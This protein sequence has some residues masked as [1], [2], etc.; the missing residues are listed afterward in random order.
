MNNRNTIENELKGLNSGLS[1]ELHGNPY[2]VPQGYF[3]G[4]AAALLNRVKEGDMSAG[5]ELATLSPL[6]AGLSRQMPYSVPEN[7]FDNNNTISAIAQEEDSLVLSFISRDMP[8]AVPAGYFANLPE[9]IMEKVV[10][11][12]AKVVPLFARKWVRMT[13]A[14]VV[15]GALALSGILY[16]NHGGNAETVTKD[17]VAVELKNASTEELNAFL[18]TT[19]VTSVPSKTAAS[20]P[21]QPNKKEVKN[22]FNDVSDQELEAF[23]EEIPADAISGIDEETEALYN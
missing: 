11:S 7:Y 2:S 10:G 3:E 5:D 22:I 18:K 15:T 9:Q 6:L 17:P 21:A 4:L 19:D 23:L 12:K 8:N 13:A 16:M 1:A 14:A 20:E